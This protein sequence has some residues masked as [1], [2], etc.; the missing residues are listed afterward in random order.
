RGEFVHPAV[1]VFPEHIGTF[2]SIADYG[3]LAHDGDHVDAILRRVV[4]RHPSRFV[5]ALLAHRTLSPTA[6]VLL[7]ESA[8]MHRIYR[9]AF[10]STALR[11]NAT[12]V[13]GSLVL[14]TNANGIDAAAL[15][16]RDA[17]LYNLSY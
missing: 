12:I 10:R 9:G 15:R 5:A 1:V 16:P 6:A 7:A 4:L 3:D 17:R 11:L 14:P 13:A 8:K 2:L